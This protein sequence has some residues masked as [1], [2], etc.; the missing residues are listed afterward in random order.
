MRRSR[1]LSLCLTI[2]RIGLAIAGGM[3]GGVV[4]FGLWTMVGLLL[5]LV[6]LVLW[7]FLMV[8]GL[9]ARKLSAF[10]LLPELLTESLAS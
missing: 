7:I 3:F 10:L 8:K 6:G 2:L 4:G 1:L 5:G 9:P